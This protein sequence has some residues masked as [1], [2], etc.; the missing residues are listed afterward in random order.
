MSRFDVEKFN[1]AP[2]PDLICCICQCVLDSPMESPCRHVFC[3][4]CIETWLANHHNCPTCRR[5]LRTRRLKPVLPLVQNMI[6][7]LQMSCDFSINGCKEI[8]ILEQYDSHLKVCDYEKLKCRFSKCGIELLRKD[9]SEHEEELCKF[10]EK[11]CNKQCGLM[12]PISVFDTHDC[13]A[14]LQKF[15]TESTA[16]VETLKKSVKELTELTKTMKKNLEDLSRELQGRRHRSPFSSPT[17]SPYSFTSSG[18]E[19]DLSNFI[20]DDYSN[21]RFDDNHNTERNIPPATSALQMYMDRTRDQR[22]VR[23]RS[24]NPNRNVEVIDLVQP[25]NSNRTDNNN[26]TNENVSTQGTSTSQ[27]PSRPNTNDVN[28]NQVLGN[29]TAAG[30]QATP[31]S[32]QDSHSN[33]AA[34]TTRVSSTRSRSHIWD[35]DISVLSSSSSSSSSSSDDDVDRDFGIEHGENGGYEE[36]DRNS[37][38]YTYSFSSTPINSPNRSVRSRSSSRSTIHDDHGSQMHR[39]IS[40]SRDTNQSVSE[41]YSEDE[42]D[43]S[44]SSTSSSEYESPARVPDTRH[45]SDYSSDQHTSV[46]LTRNTVDSWRNTYSSCADRTRSSHN[47]SLNQSYPSL[48]QTDHNTTVNMDQSTCIVESE[49]EPNSSID[50][51]SHVENSKWDRHTTRTRSAG[52]DPNIKTD[53]TTSVSSHVATLM[54]L[55]NCGS[56]QTR[57]EIPS[58]QNDVILVSVEK[59]SRPVQGNNI[60]YNSEPV[61]CNENASSARGGMSPSVNNTDTTSPHMENTVNN[62][63]EKRYV[64]VERDMENR[65]AEMSPSSFSAIWSR[66]RKHD[67]SSSSISSQERSPRKRFINSD[68]AFYGNKSSV[69][70]SI[71]DVPETVST[72]NSSAEIVPVTCQDQ[73]QVSG[74]SLENM[75]ASVITSSHTGGETTCMTTN[76]TTISV[77]SLEMCNSSSHITENNPVTQLSVLNNISSQAMCV[78]TG[79]SPGHA[80]NEAPVS[81]KT[82]MET[83]GMDPSLNT[84]FDLRGYNSDTDD[85]WEPQDSVADSASDLDYVEMTPGS[86][87]DTNGNTNHTNQPVTRNTGGSRSESDDTWE[88]RISRDDNGVSDDDDSYLSELDIDTDSS[89]EV[90]IPM[91]V[92]QLLDKYASEDHDS[93]DSWTPH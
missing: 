57:N 92:A 54:D 72:Q 47:S 34:L 51:S 41:I 12:I 88:P 90:R 52:S 3:K 35:S 37:D 86:D 25:V 89:Y 5:S 58:D 40:S 73:E 9:L 93:D 82:A 2:D 49:Q 69:S 43:I 20:L 55:S 19:S 78:V 22:N 29:N 39:G 70:S 11:K 31:E 85:T 13:F 61:K 59:G 76:T 87:T 62:A 79:F 15:A 10:R 75:R 84:T 17:Y 8:L 77:S 16:L 81:E 21:D 30:R 80:N 1:P 74:L 48:C 50:H 6:N 18:D 26:T 83:Q 36:R 42:S 64:K 91:S 68:K 66:K 44:Y 67:S 4:I 28:G 33:E 27:L 71:S 32:R 65:T 23:W 56:D 38:L 53:Q 14:E 24:G 7:R 60:Y 63:K 46:N 45:Q